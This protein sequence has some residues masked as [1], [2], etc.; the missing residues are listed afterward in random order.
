MGKLKLPVPAKDKN[1]EANLVAEFPDVN[2]SEVQRPFEVNKD[3]GNYLMET[4]QT[5]QKK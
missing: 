2:K 3:K 1:F 5:N 4:V